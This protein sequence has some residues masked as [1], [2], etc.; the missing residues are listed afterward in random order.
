MLCYKI[1]NGPN[2]GIKYKCVRGVDGFGFG[3]IPKGLLE[4]Q[5]FREDGVSSQAT[6][7]LVE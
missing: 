6:L 5:H 1:R 3:F 4:R 2:G 7:D